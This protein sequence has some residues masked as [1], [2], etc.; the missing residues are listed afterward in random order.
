MKE[1]LDNIY[2]YLW[3][4][5]NTIYVGRTKNPKS[6]HY[7]HKHRK[8][9]STYEFSVEHGVEHPKMII[10]ENDLT[11]EEGVEREKFWI[12]HYRNEG[13]YNVLNKSCGGQV[14]NQH[15]IYSD[16]ELK[17]HRK[18]YYQDNAE[19]RKKYQK[20]Y[21]SMNK[22]KI[23]DYFAKHSDEK[24]AYDKEYQKKWYE[25]NKDNEKHRERK[26]ESRKKWEK[27]NRDKLREYAR[28]WREKKKNN[29]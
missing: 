24:K 28:K 17:E 15:R 14:G 1:K 7:A 20:K 12:N 13:G 21:Y 4:E 6:R 26:K 18:K 22:N 10:I 29:S 27:L 16:D 11:I 23:K 3:E 25:K 19:D 9:E 5:L 8:A 2:I